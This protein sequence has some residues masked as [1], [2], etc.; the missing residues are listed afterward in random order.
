VLVVN[1]LVAA[2]EHEETCGGGGGD[3]HL[4]RRCR[5]LADTITD[6]LEVVTRRRAGS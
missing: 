4:A 6:G 2:A 3:R 1:A 5:N